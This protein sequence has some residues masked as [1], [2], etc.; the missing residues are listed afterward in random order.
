MNYFNDV[1]EVVANNNNSIQFF[2]YLRDVLNSQW[3]ITESAR[4][5]KQYDSTGQ[6]KKAT[7]TKKYVYAFNIQTRLLKNICKFI[8][9]ICSWN[10][11]S[12][13]AVA[14]RASEYVEVTNVPSRNQKSDCFD[15]RKGTFIKNKASKWRRLLRSVRKFYLSN[16][17]S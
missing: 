6:N 9:C 13:M 16:K 5:Q 17:L 2:I 14:R 4:K 7:K 3:P 11:S 15:D 8:S 10:T 1:T 12:W